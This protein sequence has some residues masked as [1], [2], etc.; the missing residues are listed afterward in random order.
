MATAAGFL[1]VVLG[2][3]QLF[4]ENTLTPIL[5]LLQ[6]KPNATVGNVLRLWAIVLVANLIGAVAVALIV[7]HTGLFEADVRQA[8][9]EMG[10]KAVA[11]GSAI[12][13]LRGVFAGWLIA[14]MVWLLPYAETAR[15]WVII[16]ISYL[17]GLGNFSHI[18]AGGVETFTVSALGEESWLTVLSSFVLPALI[19][20]II[21][22]VT[23]VATLNHAQIVAGEDSEVF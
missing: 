21:G 23:L 16:L 1:I 22:G 3:Q 11:P 6:R 12:V 2:R 10:H 17:V 13:L 4:T 19:G 5:P 20:N 18:I 9:A 8:F 14:L 15:V 7:A